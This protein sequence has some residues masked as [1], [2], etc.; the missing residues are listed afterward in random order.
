MKRIAVAVMALALLGG[1][2]L[3]AVLSAT[4]RAVYSVAQ[5]RS[6]LAHHPGAWVGQTILVRGI[7]LGGGFPIRFRLVHVVRPAMSI[8][9]VALA[10]SPLQPSDALVDASTQSPALGLPLAYGP[11]DPVL[12]FLRR[13]PWIGR[14]APG[15]QRL[16]A[17][18]DG[19]AVYRVRLQVAPA[20]TCGRRRCYE[21]LLLDSAPPPWYL[22]PPIP[23]PAAMR[24]SPSP[25]LV[26]HLIVSGGRVTTTSQEGRTDAPRVPTLP[27]AS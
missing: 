11:S 5:V 12:S 16:S 25:V 4:S 27:S 20:G 19:P 18:Q 6:G 8:P 13:L 10:I 2:S 21:A 17:S 26:A 15:P 14:F 22:A 23:A 3:A 1:V 24:L 7:V 9:I